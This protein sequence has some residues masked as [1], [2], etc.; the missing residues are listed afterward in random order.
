MGVMR[1]MVY[2]ES[3]LDD[4][5]ELQRAYVSGID[6]RVYP[7]R[8]EVEGNV[9]ACR[10]ANSESGKVHVALPV[11][12]F[13][14]PCASTFPSRIWVRGG[15]GTRAPKGCGTSTLACRGGR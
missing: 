15:R 10:R 3:L 2:P 12:G 11:E 5:P 7:T 4:W 1:F 14:R 8:I 9:I 13:G 6:G